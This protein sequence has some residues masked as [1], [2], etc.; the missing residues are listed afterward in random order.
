MKYTTSYL[1]A[2]TLIVAIV[3]AVGRFFDVGQ[4]I[5]VALL[6][7]FLL[8]PSVLVFLLAPFR[9]MSVNTRQGVTLGFLIVLG[10]PATIIAAVVV[11][12]ALGAF[13]FL[14]AFLVW[15]PQIALLKDL[16]S[17]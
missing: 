8:A 11:H 6:A 12:P 16:Q 17:T 13:L 5:G 7:G 14:F 15:A 3:C 4:A 10:L 2:L 9:S 1:M